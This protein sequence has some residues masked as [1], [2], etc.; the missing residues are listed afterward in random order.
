MQKLLTSTPILMAGFLSTTLM[1]WMDPALSNKFET[2]GGGVT[3]TSYAKAEW[4]K[5]FFFVVAAMGA[6][7]AILAVF[8]P[9]DNALFLNYN[10]WKKSAIVLGV[11]SGVS[12]II[13]LLL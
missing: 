4:L 1:L 13:A 5:D 10:N 11:I 8:Y 12:L 3:G 2:I 7:G 9:R 6:L